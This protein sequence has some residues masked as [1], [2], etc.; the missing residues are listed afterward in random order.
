MTTNSTPV[1]AFLSAI[2]ILVITTNAVF[3]QCAPPSM[4]Y[5]NA[6]LVSG[7][8]GAV[9]AKYKFTSVTPGVDAYFTVTQIVGGAKLT[10]IDDLTYGYNAA[11]QPVIK[12]PTSQGAN[13]SYVAFKLEFK[14]TSDGSNHV[15]NCFS[16]SFIDV[17]G[18]GNG[19]REFVAAG[20]YDSY[21]VSNVSTL[22]ISQSNGLLKATG[23][24]TQYM[25]LDTSAW[26][27][28]INYNYKNTDKVGEIRIGNKTN[29]SFTVQD[30]YSCGYFKGIAIPTSIVLGV[31]YASFDAV[32]T[33]DAVKLNWITET[34]TN[35]SHFEVERSFDMN[36]FKTIGVVLGGIAHI[37][38]GKSYQYNDKAADLK[39]R[40]IVYYR[41]KQF[42]MDGKVS[43]SKILAVRLQD[44]MVSSMQV[45]P[46][47]FVENLAVRYNAST[48]GLAEIRLVNMAGQ[49]ILSAKATITKGSNNIQLQGLGT[50]SSGMYVARLIVN[51]VVVENH[52]VIKN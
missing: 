51:G 36:N 9:N 24:V 27:T 16:L 42:D 4:N 38:N 40:N 23:A 29:N 18:D 39:G 10:S 1:R 21:T 46:N 30:R 17:D 48:S 19:V 12:T 20:G 35:H 49:T 37:G 26:V 25:G 14:N 32:K 45:T 47:P 5:A 44:E 15:Y 43:Y 22:S 2:I 52:K 33:E 41:L 7:N 8:P 31:K 11:W 28:N 34:E 13:E 6:T 3:A 50:L